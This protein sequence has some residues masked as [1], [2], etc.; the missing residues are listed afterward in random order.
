M[1]MHSLNRI[2][3]NI[4]I[5]LPNEQFVEDQKICNSQVMLTE[6]ECIS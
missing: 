3:Y 1:K 2:E 6:E 5:Y 4:F